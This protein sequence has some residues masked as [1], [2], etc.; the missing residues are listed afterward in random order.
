MNARLRLRRM[1]TVDVFTQ[2]PTQG[3]PVS[4]VLDGQGLNAAQMQAF[5][6][7]SQL[8]E[9]TFV[10]P[11][12]S[13]E[14]AQGAD[15]GVRIFSPLGEMNFAGHPTLGT[16]HAWLAQGG[17][18]Q[19]SDRIVQACRAGL[20]DIQPTPQGLA[21]AAPSIHTRPLPAAMARIYAA[22]GLNPAC[23]QQQALL[24]V[25]TPWLCLRLEH[26][27]AL[28]ALQPDPVQLR[29][30][31]ALFDEDVGLGLCAL[32]PQAETA[33]SVRAFTLDGQEDPVTGSLNACLAH[34][35]Q[36]VDVLATPY[37][38]AQG[39]AVGRHG[40]VGLMHDTQ[41]R[42]WVSGHSV[43]CVDGQVLL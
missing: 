28:H 3:N 21:F 30:L 2:Q 11:P 32:T 15:Y 43:V 38:A 29:A 17:Q 7:W 12:T 23:V 42:L 24:D 5:T 34:W 4:V 8:C 1:M 36:T 35:M 10:F 26:A 27:E 9:A 19:R 25:G 20:I 37:I 40:R 22:L 31:A 41:H 14:K 16:C 33:L 13:A 6:Q 18:P 39:C